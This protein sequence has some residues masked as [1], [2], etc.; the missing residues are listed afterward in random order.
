MIFLFLGPE[1]GISKYCDYNPKECFQIS[2]STVFK[3]KESNTLMIEQVML[4]PTQKHVW[5]FLDVAAPDMRFIHFW[6]D[7]L[8]LEQNVKITV[9]AFN[10]E[11]K[12]EITKE[13][14]TEMKQDF[15]C[16]VEILT[17]ASRLRKYLR[18]EKSHGLSARCVRFM[19]QY[20]NWRYC[21][22]K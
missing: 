6:K 19:R 13:A 7:R 18:E 9:A 16:D 4:H 17:D 20:H 21:S 22:F 12:W 15:K 11:K 2:D 1:E 5:L 10:C 14:F 3:P 8:S